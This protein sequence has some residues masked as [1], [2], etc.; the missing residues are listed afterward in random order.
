MRTFVAELQA[1]VVRYRGEARFWRAVAGLLAVVV[2]LLVLGLAVVVTRRACTPTDDG[3]NPPEVIDRDTLFPHVGPSVPRP[4]S[5]PTPA[6][7]PP[8]C[9]KPLSGL[10]LCLMSLLAEQVSVKTYGIRT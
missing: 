7:F 9:R 6:G 5:T 2:L 10:D 8:T 4:G 1:Q 3:A